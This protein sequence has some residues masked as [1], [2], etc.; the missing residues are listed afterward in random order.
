MTEYST[1]AP[2]FPHTIQINAQHWRSL[3]LGALSRQISERSIPDIIFC[4]ST[5]ADGRVTTWSSTQGPSGS[6]G[7][8]VQERGGVPATLNYMIRHY[9][10]EGAT[11][12]PAGKSTWKL[13]FDTGSYYGLEHTFFPMVELSFLVK[14]GEHFHVPLLL[15]PYSFTTY[16]GS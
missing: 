1:S 3:D 8:F 13:N 11:G 12:L 7:A 9:G 10:A 15:G 5:N 14:E 16:R 2:Y 4:A 6:E